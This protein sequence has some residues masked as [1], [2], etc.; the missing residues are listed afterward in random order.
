[1]ICRVPYEI[2]SKSSFCVTDTQ[3]IENEAPHHVNHYSLLL[4]LSH[5]TLK[6]HDFVTLDNKKQRS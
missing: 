6:L 3:T 1:M 5:E 4:R 2:E